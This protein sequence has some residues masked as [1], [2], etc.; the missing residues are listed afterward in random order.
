MIKSLDSFKEYLINIKKCSNNTLDA[1]MRD[2]SNFISYC[3]MNGTSDLNHINED[4]IIKYLDYLKFIG[5]SDSTKTRI[6][7]SLRSYFKYLA[8]NNIIKSNPSEGIKNPRTVKKMPGVLDS[9]EIM[10]LL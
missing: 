2:I 9:K 4:F 3:S 7:A 8:Q 6:T 10:L 5:K 1:Y